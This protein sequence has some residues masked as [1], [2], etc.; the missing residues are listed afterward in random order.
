MPH[1]P[2]HVE[3]KARKYQQLSLAEAGQFDRKFR[4]TKSGPGMD[5]EFGARVP[6]TGWEVVSQRRQAAGVSRK[7]RIKA[8]KESQ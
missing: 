1:A 5:A 8:K 6:T 7:A 2:T 4:V 3:E